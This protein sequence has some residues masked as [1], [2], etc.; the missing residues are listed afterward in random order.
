MERI[1]EIKKITGDK[2]LNYLEEASKINRPALF[3]EYKLAV[4]GCLL[5]KLKE[6]TNVELEKTFDISNSTIS[7]FKVK[8]LKSHEKI[9]ELIKDPEF[10]KDPSF[11]N[12]MK[13]KLSIVAKSTI[14]RNKFYYEYNKKLFPEQKKIQEKIRNEVRQSYYKRR[15]VKE[16]NQKVDF[17]A[18]KNRIEK[19]VHILATDKSSETTQKLAKKFGCPIYKTKKVKEILDFEI[20]RI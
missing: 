19:K 16:F 20:R 10:C 11:D 17:L 5:P 2:I 1:E 13:Y 15:K 14:A 6:F 12:F 7:R 3:T 4:I 18:K 9:K 8:N